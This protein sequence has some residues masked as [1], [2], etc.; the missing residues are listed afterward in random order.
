M[1]ILPNGI[2]KLRDSFAQGNPRSRLIKKNI[3]FSAIIKGASV[4][5]NIL[6]IPMVISYVSPVKFGV[7]VTLCSIVGWLNFFDIG[8][9]NGLRNRFAESKARG[10]FQEARILVSTTYALLALFI[11]CV[12]TVF[13][14]V[15]Q[16]L[17]WSVILNVSG[18]MAGELS[19]VVLIFFSCVC[20]TLV[21]KTVNTLLIADQEPSKAALN[22]L[23]GQILALIVIALLTQFT[24]GSL[25]Y[26]SIALGL[27]PIL[28]LLPATFLYFHSGYAFCSPNFSTIRLSYGYGL[29]RLGVQFFIIQTSAIILF[30]TS[31]IVITQVT[32]PLGV[33]VYNID[34]KYFITLNS[35]FMI[36]VAPV[37]SSFT[38]AYTKGDFDWMHRILRKLN[39]IW[40]F[41]IPILLAMLA[42]SNLVF[43]VLSRN[44]V[45]VPLTNSLYMAL[46]VLGYNLLVINI[47]IING[48]G[49][50]KLQLYI[51][52]VLCILYIPVAYSL[53]RVLGIDGVI[54]SNIIV[55]SVHLFFSRKQVTMLLNRTADGIWNK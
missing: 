12:W 4:G 24:H 37:W 1:K 38:D 34:Y 44:T 10:D 36:I 43:E 35:L 30:Q 48:I 47:Y 20:V 2:K 41:S 23:L 15:N 11:L 53:C 13:F 33:T 55:T 17:D 25:L 50:V 26:I 45:K 19:R 49:K 27:S 9:G 14:F 51:N 42:I 5:I 40:L 32:G 28:V 52:I 31:N 7:W 46:Y 3:A 16:Y 39:L 6:F 22:D 21:L 18:D 54:I 8:L 29:A